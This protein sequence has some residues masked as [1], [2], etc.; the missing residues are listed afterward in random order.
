[1]TCL[2]LDA[3]WNILHEKVFSFPV[4]EYLVKRGGIWIGPYLRLPEGESVD[5]VRHVAFELTFREREPAYSSR[6]KIPLLDSEG[7]H[8]SSLITAR[9]IVEEEGVLS[10]QLGGYIVRNDIAVD[11]IID[12][13][14]HPDYPLHIYF[15]VYE[16]SQDEYG[17]T[18]Y[19]LAI[20]MTS[21]EED[22]TA[23][24]PLI[25]AL[26]RIIRRESQEGTVTVLYERTGISP[27]VAE[28]LAIDF[29][30]V[31]GTGVYHIDIQ[32]TDNNS[33]KSTS[34]SARIILG[35]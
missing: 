9:E 23:A 16:L 20:S 4:A 6:D 19:N 28:H 17:A 26:G 18:S 13:V 10:L 11:P 24:N 33:G 29:R 2:V 5:E 8:L 25:D 34:Q 32:I 12:E 15:E 3:E 21:L 30:Q 22:R 27:M 7:L 35:K 14:H 31:S 1:M